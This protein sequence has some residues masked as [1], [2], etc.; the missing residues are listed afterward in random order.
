MRKIYI[1]GPITGK[2]NGNVLGF[3]EASA[4]ILI[5][6][7][8]PLNPLLNGLPP[9]APWEAH[10]RADIKMICDADAVQ[11]I[12]GWSESRGARIEHG[13]ALSLGIPILYPS[14]EP[15]SSVRAG[16]MEV[17]NV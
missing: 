8:Y 2:P 1:S 15:P 9:D 10:M 3:S 16:R 17:V 11:M 12:D 5:A 7:N 6:G 4:Q 14:N 13:I